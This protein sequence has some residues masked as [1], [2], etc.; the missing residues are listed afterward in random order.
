[1]T[2]M[3]IVDVVSQVWPGQQELGNVRFGQN[4]GE[5]I[6]ITTWT[7]PDI[8]EPSVEELEA[9]IP[10]LQTQFDIWYFIN[11][12]T[13]LIEPFMDSVAA[14]RQYTS[15]ITCASYAN[16]TVPEWKA[17]AEAFVAWRDQILSYTMTQVQLMQGEQRSVPTFE[18]FITELPVIVWPS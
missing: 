5:P 3:T 10:G 6:F 9:M 14:Q 4:P 18:E 1:M 15:T 17:Q 16:S 8:P 13:P 7:V 11:H 2:T 12:G